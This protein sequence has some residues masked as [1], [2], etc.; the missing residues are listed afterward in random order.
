MKR[1][2]ALAMAFASVSALALESEM[3]LTSAELKANATIARGSVDNNQTS[4]VA[5]R[6][7]QLQL[8]AS[9]CGRVIIS[10]DTMMAAEVYG[11]KIT[12]DTC[13][14]KLKAQGNCEA[15][16][17]PRNMAVNPNTPSGVIVG[18][19]KYMVCLKSGVSPAASGSQPA[20]K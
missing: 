11:F 15:G 18:A 9:E 6:V 4:V 12:A 16:F 7:I 13:K 5:S 3:S 19:N 20:A 14:V 8:M 10:P 17:V 2:F 1:F